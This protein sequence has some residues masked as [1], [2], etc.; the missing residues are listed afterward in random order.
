LGAFSISKHFTGGWT[1]HG[2]YTWGKS[3]DYTSS[4]DNDNGNGGAENIFDA[5]HVSAQYGRANF[6]SR[7]RFSGD[8]AWDVRGVGNGFAHTVTS[9]WTLAP[10]IILQSGQPF[11][12]MNSAAFDPIWNYSS[13]ANVFTTGCLV[14]GNSGGDYNAD[15]YGYD[16][17]NTPKFGNHLSGVS[18]SRFYNGVFASPSVFPA[19]V[20]GHEGNLG[21]NTYDGPGFAVVNMTVQRTFKVARLGEAGSFEI[22][23]EFFN[24]FNRVNLTIPNSDMNGS[25]FG[26]STGQSTPRQIQ[27]LANIRF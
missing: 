12:V 11:T 6:D 25:Y 5:Q 2:I 19:P 10:V 4:N 17:P 21:K 26:Q 7:Q 22:R 3:L 1:A 8:L 9:G 18:R 23:G 13:C 16:V 27:I 14:V 24:L 15:G 20:F